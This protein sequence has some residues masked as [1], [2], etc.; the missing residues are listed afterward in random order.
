MRLRTALAKSK[1]LVSIR[2]LQEIGLSYTLEYAKRFGFKNKDL[3]RDLTL[4]LGT[5]SATPLEMATSYSSFANG[6]FKINSH[7]IRKIVD[8]HGDEIYNADPVA[9]C[10]SNCK[11]NSELLKNSMKNPAK[12]IMKPYVNYQINSM[13]RSVAQVGTAARS[14]RILNRQDLAGKTGT[15]DDQ[16]DAWFCGFT[17]NKVTTVWIGFDRIKPLGRKETAAGAALPLWIDFMKTALSP[18][19]SHPLPAPSGLINVEL[20]AY[21]GMPPNQF[22]VETITEALTAEQIPTEEEIQAYMEE[23]RDEILER[24]NME[25]LADADEATRSRQL[26]RL[27]REAMQREQNEERRRQARQREEV[28]IQQLRDNN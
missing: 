2:L 18:K 21:T 1:N 9:V 6:G 27:K 15:T 8:R 24:V 10:A 7:F 17:P 25:A 12:R 22:T 13:L 20:D 3:P 5:G 4:S 11:P 23:H 28:R 16:K 26:E 19:E 14:S